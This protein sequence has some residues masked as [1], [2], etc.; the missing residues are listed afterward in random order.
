MTILKKIHNLIWCLKHSCDL[1][2]ILGKIKRLVFSD[3]KAN[4]PSTNE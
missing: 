2:M 3:A 4:A 1:A